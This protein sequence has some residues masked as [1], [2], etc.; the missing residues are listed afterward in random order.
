MSVFVADAEELSPT[1]GWVDWVDQ[2]QEGKDAKHYYF[3][4]NIKL[5]IDNLYC[6]SPIC[7]KFYDRVWEKAMLIFFWTMS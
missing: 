6:W 1:G 5:N 4:T 3:H 2:D 7:I